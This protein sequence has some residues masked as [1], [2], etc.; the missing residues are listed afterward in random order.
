ME[1]N[2]IL[3]ER[4]LQDKIIVILTEFKQKINLPLLGCRREPAFKWKNQ[5]R[6][7]YKSDVQMHNT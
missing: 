7:L 6:F 3:E 1:L 2:N 4:D 5:A